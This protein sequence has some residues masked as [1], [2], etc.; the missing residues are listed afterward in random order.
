MGDSVDDATV[1]ANLVY[2]GT[3]VIGGVMLVIIFVSLVGTMLIAGVTQT[4]ISLVKLGQRLFVY[5]PEQTTAVEDST[6]AH[7]RNAVLAKADAILAA[8]RVQAEESAA[9]AKAEEAAAAEAERMRRAAKTE[10]EKAPAARAT[11]ASEKAALTLAFPDRTGP[12]TG[13]QPLVK[14]G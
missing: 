12:F 6:P 5:R 1:V 13:T 9:V 10:A 11:A 8:S 14:A 3:L 2:S 7:V 4:L